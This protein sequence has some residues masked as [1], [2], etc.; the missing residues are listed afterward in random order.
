[1]ILRIT[2]WVDLS[3]LTPCSRH[4]FDFAVT[5][6]ADGSW[7]TAPVKVA[8]GNRPLPRLV[9]LAGIHG[10][11]P[12]GMLSLLDFRKACDPAS[13]QGIIIL[14]PVANPPAFAAHQR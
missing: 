9:A 10:D 2:E 1:M 7:L 8:V 5:R 13:L 6:L 3:T 4:D 11:E 14:V 12:E